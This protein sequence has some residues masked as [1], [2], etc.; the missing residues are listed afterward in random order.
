MPTNPTFFDVQQLLRS[1]RDQ[2]QPDG[3]RNTYYRSYTS[4]ATLEEAREELEKLPAGRIL[5][6]EVVE[7]KRTLEPVAARRI[8]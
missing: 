1:P 3:R 2:Q 5:K 4:C 6:C 8:I 7:V